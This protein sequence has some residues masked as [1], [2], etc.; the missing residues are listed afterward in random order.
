M[1]GVEGPDPRGEETFETGDARSDT[2]PEVRVRAG[3][4]APL[5]CYSSTNVTSMLTR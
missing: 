1:A 2:S 4:R 3:Q 5:L